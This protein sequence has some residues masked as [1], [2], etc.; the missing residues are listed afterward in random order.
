MNPTVSVCIPLYNSEKHIGETIRSVLD[1]SFEEFEIIVIDDA[2]TDRSIEVVRSFSDARIAIHENSTNIGA[3]P[4]FNRSLSLARGEF[5]KLLCGDDPLYPSCL[6]Y[7]LEALRRPGHEG[8][9]MVSALRNIIDGDGR[10]VRRGRVSSGISG[11]V[12]GREGVEA[13]IRAGRNLIGEPS[14]VLMRRRAAHAA[15]PFRDDLPYVIDL[16]MWFRILAHGDLFFIPDVLS[17]FRVSSASWSSRLARVQA[18]QLRTLLRRTAGDHPDKISRWSVARGLGRST[19][20]TWARR[21][22]YLIVKLRA[23]TQRMG[24]TAA[25]AR[26]GAD[27]GQHR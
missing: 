16:D 6:E 19:I 14:S 17:A 13:C 3:G 18:T 15:G 11:H 2:S 27:M 7:Q 24:S 12:N 5:V 26:L 21:L 1:Q 20:H 9:D 25:Q 22:A 10:I 8:I 23:R 4:N